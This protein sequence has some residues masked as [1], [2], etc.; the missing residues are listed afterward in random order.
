MLR[1]KLGRFFS[2]IGHKVGYSR[3]VI[4]LFGIV[5][6]FTNFNNYLWKRKQGVVK[7]D[8]LS[9]YSYLPAAIVHGDLTFAFIDNDPKFFAGKISNKKTPEGGSFQKMTMGL[10]FLYLPFFLLGHLAAWVTGAEMNGFSQPYMFFLQFAAL[11]YVL[12]AMLV[13]RKLLLQLVSDRIVALVILVIGFGTNLFFYTTIEAAM[14]HAFN[15]SLFVFFV[16]L[17]MRWHKQPSLKIA[18]LIGLVFGLIGL[19]RPTNGL[20]ALFFILYD[21]QNVSEQYKKLANHWKQLLILVLISFLVVLPQLLFWKFNTGHWIFYSYGKEGFFFDNPQIWRALFSYRKGWLVYTPVMIFGLAGILALRRQFR[22]FLVPIVVFVP[23]NFYSIFSWWDWTYGGS[24]GSRPLIDSYVLMAVSMAAL[25]YFLE[26]KSRI[27]FR[28]IAGI[29]LLLIGFN[30]FQTMQ[31]KYG[32]IHYAHMSKAAYW[33]NFGK[34]KTDLD[35]SDLLEPMNYDSLVAGKYVVVPIVRHTIGPDAFTSFETLDRY[36]N[37]FLAEDGH[38]AF[39]NVELQVDSESKSGQYA[40]MLYGENRFAAGIEF[41]V[42][43]GE[44]YEMSIWK[45][46]VDARAALVFAAP[47]PKDFYIQLE[48]VSETDSAGW[49]KIIFS[50]EIPD[51][52]ANKKYRAYVWSKTNDTVFFDDFKI[53]KRLR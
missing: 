21:F 7:H 15:F 22:S 48:A 8:V 3:A 29:M 12:A 4:L 13:L 35:F 20:I 30:L 2:Q 40:V 26:K 50:A 34:L 41:W 39:A 23:L 44:I 25:L 42:R 49:G 17:S 10:A 36:N 27:G 16:W 9:Y 32:L 45:K 5:V 18:A 28:I 53:I 19:I 6:I 52:A 11:F 43:K 37:K 51:E 14:S 47:D 1:I 46:P 38:Y 24:F 31:Y 33:H